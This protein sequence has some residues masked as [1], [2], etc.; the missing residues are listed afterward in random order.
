MGDSGDYI[1]VTL[2]GRQGGGMLSHAYQIGVEGC[3]G[4]GHYQAAYVGQAGCSGQRQPSG[5]EWQGSWSKAVLCPG[6]R[7]GDRMMGTEG[8]QTGCRWHLPLSGYFLKY[9]LSLTVS[10][11]MPSNPL[12]Y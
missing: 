4:G 9:I 7:T 12:S 3:H 5:K 2:D 6:D 10:W 11:L 8:N 1:S